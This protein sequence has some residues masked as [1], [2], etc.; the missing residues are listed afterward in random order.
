MVDT[1]TSDGNERQTTDT[2]TTNDNNPHTLILNRIIPKIIPG[3]IRP[4]DQTITEVVAGIGETLDARQMV[5]PKEI[6][7]DRARSGVHILRNPREAR[8]T[9]RDG[10]TPR[11][12]NTVVA[13]SRST[14]PVQ[15]CHSTTDLPIRN[16]NQDI[17]NPIGPVSL[18]WIKNSDKLKTSIGVFFAED[19]GLKHILS[20]VVG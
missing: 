12:G 9:G 1:H 19:R 18:Q 5:L 13:A 2:D 15:I 4:I 14:F 6:V 20:N 11:Y 7:T 3:E 17:I 8:R 10:T 16:R